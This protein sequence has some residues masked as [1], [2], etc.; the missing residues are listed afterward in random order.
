MGR[1]AEYAQSNIRKN[2]AIVMEAAVRQPFSM[3][4]ADQDLRD[5]TE[6]C[7]EILKKNGLAMEYMS[8]RLKRNMM[9]VEIAINQNPNSLVYAHI[10]VR[11][12]PGIQKKV[13]EL[14][15]GKGRG[16]RRPDLRDQ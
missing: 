1:A 10:D 4:F 13:K 5:D 2:K 6:F 12:D 11:N 14:L 9:L 7:M 16:R 8:K 15:E 3:C